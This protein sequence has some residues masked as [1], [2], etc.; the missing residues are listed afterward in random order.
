MSV[1]HKSAQSAISRR[2]I[3]AYASP[4]LITSLAWMPLGYVIVKFYAKYTSLDLATIG[5][6]ILLARLF[7]AFSDPI[8]AYLSDSLNTRWGRR[9]PWIIIS[10]PITA[11]GFALMFMPPSEI[12]WSYFLTANICLYVG[13]T[14][15]EITH[16]AW[17]LE[18]VRDTKKRSELGVLLKVFAYA[19]SLLFFAFPF[20]FN[21]DPNSSEF[22]PSVMS[23]LGLAIALTFPILVLFSVNVMPTETKI[24]GMPY[25]FK[26]ALRDI[27]ANRAFKIY[28]SAFVAWALADAVLVALF[29]IYVDVHLNASAMEGIILLAAYCSRLFAAPFAYKLLQKYAHKSLWIYATVGNA[30]LF[31]LLALFPSSETAPYLIAIYAAIL[32]TLDC[33]IGILIITLLGDVIDRD[34][35]QTGRDKA[36]SYKA[37]INLFE[38]TI[39]ALGTSGS[40]AIVG[41]AGLNVGDNNS[42]QAIFV[43]IAVLASVPTLLNLTSAV[44]MCRYPSHEITSQHAGEHL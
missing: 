41:M 29:L 19:G 24:G 25:T 4:T 34:A 27:A 20:L 16:I 32:G 43:L 11:T 14:F 37:A 22:T 15:F 42:Q 33:L 7:D 30:V 39:R 17:G 31:P 9:K 2:K 26:N 3:T 8:V 40:L 6:I 23:G 5:S 28:A 18:V 21:S 13:W 35:K 38:K 12:H 10:A 1:T 44:I 36:A